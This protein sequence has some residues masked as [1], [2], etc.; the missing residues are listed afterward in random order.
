VSWSLRDVPDQTGRVAVVTGATSGLGLATAVALASRGAHV[1]LTARDPGRGEAALAR[2]R[3]AGAAEV[4]PLDLTSLDSVRA[5]AERVGAA[6]DRLDLLVNNAGVMGTPLRRTAEGFELQLGTNHLGPFALTGLLLPRLLATPGSRVV[7]VS[8]LVARFG[9]IRLDDLNRDRRR[10]RRW[11]AYADSKLANLL[12]TFELSRR[13]I[14]AGAGTTAL[15]AHPGLA[16]T[17]LGKDAGRLQQAAMR[18]VH[19]A[20]QEASS[21]AQSQIRA[22]TDPSLATGTYVGPGGP[23]GSSGP[24]VPVAAPTRAW[25]R[26]AMTGL[27]D[28]SEQLTGVTYTLTADHPH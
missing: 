12:F 11:E 26:A 28:R 13:L 20:A 5:F 19:V 3:E 10:Y 24:P 18:L 6:Y 14:E 21:G 8:S 22:A 2:V 4:L 25:D 15:A 27:W 17:A 7:T 9:R 23:G 16:V 1:V